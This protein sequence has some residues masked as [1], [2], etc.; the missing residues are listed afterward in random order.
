[1]AFLQVSL[2]G[3]SPAFSGFYSGPDL[4]SLYA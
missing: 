2:P 4:P 3:E 1:M